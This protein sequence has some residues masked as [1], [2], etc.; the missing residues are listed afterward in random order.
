MKKLLFLF[1]FVPVLLFAEAP[2]CPLSMPVVYDLTGAIDDG[3]SVVAVVTDQAEI[4]EFSFDSET[5]YLTLLTDAQFYYALCLDSAGHQQFLYMGPQEVGGGVAIQELQPLPS[6]LGEGAKAAGKGALISLG[7]GTGIFLIALAA[8]PGDGWTALDTYITDG[9]LVHHDSKDLIRI[10]YG[11]TPNICTVHG[12]T[13]CERL[14]RLT[15]FKL[16]NCGA[17]I[18]SRRIGILN[19][20]QR[21]IVVVFENDP[22]PIGPYA[23]WFK[24]NRYILTEH[25]KRKPECTSD[26]GLP[27]GHGTLIFP[28]VQALPSLIFAQC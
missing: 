7:T 12:F 4:S 13:S 20:L 3:Y 25:S 1:A 23:V 17:W 15:C 5:D 6:S 28:K 26:K 9:R 27:Q 24:V 16:C 11:P 18:D 2:P 10:G 21:R 19:E 22:V 14:S 8:D